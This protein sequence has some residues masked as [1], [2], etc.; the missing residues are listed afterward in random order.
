MRGFSDGMIRVRSSLTVL[1]GLVVACGTGERSIAAPGGPGPSQSTTLT[2]RAQLE[3]S[4]AG[5][6]S[7]LAWNGVVPGAEVNL[8]RS[9]TAEWL[10][11]VTSADGEALFEDLVPGRYR[12]Y[13]GRR[14][15]QEE[16]SSSGGVVRAFGGGRTFNFTDGGQIVLELGAD[17]G[18]AGLV[19]SEVNG[20]SPPPWEVGG[21][22][23][24]DG[25]YV[26]VFNN[27]STTRFLDGVVIGAAYAL[28]FNDGPLV[29]CA[30]TQS[31]RTDPSGLVTRWAIAF[32]GSGGEY[33]IQPGEAKVVAVSAIDHSP[34]HP[35]LLDL[36]DADFEI[37]GSQ[38]ADNPAV[39]NMFDVGLAAWEPGWFLAAISILFLSEPIEVGA[40]PITF[41]D[42]NGAGYVQ[43]PANRLVDV[44]AFRAIWPDRDIERPPCIPALHPSFDRYEG[45]LFEI[46]FGVEEPAESLQRVVLR[47]EDG[48]P[49]LQD[50]NT[51]AA[52]FA[53]APQT[54]GWIP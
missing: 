45:G 9:G 43:I 53:F 6:G 5:L 34:V 27:S 37:G 51:T 54:P 21:G 18:A 4:A 15:S 13:A 12:L 29:P 2:V 52:D 42:V 26:E 35:Q 3:S 33:P 20:A 17:D 32:P 11:A 44:T 19:I 1:C 31:L 41:R 14:L 28:V 8:L 40:L 23:Y 7:A 36:R 10:A 50:T 39:P 49:V 24:Q 30:A 46:G 38:N 16:A 47:Y 25:L 22:S 48:R